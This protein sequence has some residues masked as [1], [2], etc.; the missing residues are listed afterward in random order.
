MAWMASSLFIHHDDHGAVTD[1]VARLLEDTRHRADQEGI[2]DPPGPVLI[3]AAHRGWIAILGASPWVNDLCWLGDQLSTSCQAKVVSAVILANCY[4][5]RLA[6]HE[7][8]LTSLQLQT[9]ETGWLH[10]AEETQQMPL[11]EDVELRA[12]RELH[13]LQVPASLVLLGT[14][15][16]GAASLPEV[17][18]GQGTQLTPGDAKVERGS[19]ELKGLDYDREDPPVLPMDLSR[20]FGVMLFDIRYVEGRPTRQSLERLLQIEEEFLARALRAEP[21]ANVSLTVTYHAGVYQDEVDYF[22]RAR[23]HVT[24]AHTERGDHRPSWWQ[25]WR[26]LGRLR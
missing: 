12:W 3:S 7:A 18:L 26:Y 21:G 11:Y 20:D 4:R 16:L 23:G 19:L 8:G 6:T 25:F 14:C 10:Q 1:A 5:L 2:L 9:P 22:L 24:A 13:Q 15:P 17:A